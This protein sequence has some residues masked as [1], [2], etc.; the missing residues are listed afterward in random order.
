MPAY[1]AQTQA[2]CDLTQQH[3]S[4]HSSF[5]SSFSS[6]FGTLLPVLSQQP[7]RYFSPHRSGGGSASTNNHGAG[8]SAMLRKKPSVTVPSSSSHPGTVTAAAAAAA[9]AA[10][11]AAAAAAAAAPH[12]S[13]GGHF[14][15]VTA[16]HSRFDFINHSSSN[17][18][19]NINSGGGGGGGVGGLSSGGN[20][21]P[22]ILTLLSSGT[23]TNSVGTATAGG[24]TSGG[25]GAPYALTGSSTGGG[26]TSLL[27]ASLPLPSQR[28]ASPEA[29]LQA[30][31][32]GYINYS[33]KGV[34]SDTGANLSAGNV[35]GSGAGSVGGE[36]AIGGF[37]FTDLRP[38]VLDGPL[39]EVLTLSSEGVL[40][41]NDEAKAALGL[42]TLGGGVGSRE[43]TSKGVSDAYDED[44]SGS[45][46]DD[47]PPLSPLPLT[48]PNFTYAPAQSSSTGGCINNCNTTNNN[49]ASPLI[50]GSA[51][52]NSLFGINAN[53]S[54]SS[55]ISSAAAAAATAHSHSHHHHQPPLPLTSLFTDQHL[56]A[57]YSGDSSSSSSGE[58]VPPPY[59]LRDA[60]L[61]YLASGADVLTTMN[62]SV[63]P[64]Y[65]VEVL[66][67]GRSALT[68]A[69]SML[70]CHD[71]GGVLTSPDLSTTLSAMIS[72]TGEAAYQARAQ[73]LRCA[74]EALTFVRQYVQ[75]HDTETALALSTLNANLSSGSNAKKGKSN[76]ADAAAE[77]EAT[78]KEEAARLK[79]FREDNLLRKALL[80]LSEKR[81]ELARYAHMI[82]KNH[83]VYVVGYVAPLPATAA[84]ALATA[85][86]N[87]NSAVLASATN[88][89]GS[90][91]TDSSGTSASANA[92]ERVNVGLSE[93]D[94]VLVFFYQQLL[95]EHTLLCT[96]SHNSS[97]SGDSASCDSAIS[98]TIANA[99]DSY[100]ETHP[101]DLLRHDTLTA[102]PPAAS[103]RYPPKSPLDASSDASVSEETVQRL[104]LELVAV[105]LAP[106]CDAFLC[107]SS[108]GI[109]QAELTALAAMTVNSVVNKAKASDNKTLNKSSSDAN[110][111]VDVTAS[112]TASANPQQV[113]V[114]GTSTRTGTTAVPIPVWVSF[115]LND[116]DYGVPRLYSC[117]T[118]AQAVDR[119]LNSLPRFVDGYLFNC[120]SPT[121]VTAALPLLRKI[122]KRPIGAYAKLPLLSHAPSYS[123]AHAH[124]HPH[125]HAHAHSQTPQSQ[126]LQSRPQAQAQTQLPSKLG[127]FNDIKHVNS[128]S[129]KLNGAHFR[130]ATGVLKLTAVAGNSFT[131]DDNATL[132]LTGSQWQFQGE[133]LK[134]LYLIYLIEIVYQ[135]ILFFSWLT[136]VSLQT[137]LSSSL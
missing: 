40:S 137:V 105:S 136:H 85:V 66:T 74:D 24:F 11:N 50:N 15:V 31:R 4:L 5:R 47:L 19:N 35:V 20:L 96:P 125:A 99:T 73:A 121:A 117:E 52:M 133:N 114:G 42:I 65:L 10:A 116:T 132:H 126:R 90:H 84:A 9:V 13:G 101:A 32:S 43:A 63:Q 91:D 17:S 54:I 129:S 122:T 75:Q 2:Y 55:N 38:L 8:V 28:L 107:E 7:A 33:N 106:W 77:E 36:T 46:S 58:R 103:T 48:I 127:A 18:N 22:F 59:I 123:H 111:G 97:T 60:H 56:S 113:T 34:T 70:R 67:E 93:S 30:F 81:P 14:D 16:Q 27:D 51:A 41:L 134:L 39:T 64:E 80:E 83:G 6:S 128:F 124:A 21:S 100:A 115:R 95:A 135:I 61:A 76:H 72:Q 109:Q 12:H 29:R 69:A 78:L 120:S 88:S 45:S 44:L 119:L 94:A 87:Y 82:L 86:T 110:T 131:L 79:S 57:P 130:P 25:V 112:A 68:T 118:L 23:A 71:N 62:L 102:T 92:R 1:A 108:H 49:N 37:P 53:N 26:L 98:S 89:S 3:A 104:W